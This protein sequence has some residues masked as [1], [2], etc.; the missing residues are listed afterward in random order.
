[1]RR[2]KTMKAKIELNKTISELNYEENIELCRLVILNESIFECMSTKLTHD[3]IFEDENIENDKVKAKIILKKEEN[4]NEAEIMD[5]IQILRIMQKQKNIIDFEI[6]YEELFLATWDL[7][8][9]K[10]GEYLL[11][12]SPYDDDEEEYDETPFHSLLNE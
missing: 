6:C 10:D 1:M 12:G 4:D 5:Y 8:D 2:T 3:K 11:E 7:N 9:S